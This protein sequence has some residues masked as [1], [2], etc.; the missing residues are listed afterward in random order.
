MTKVSLDTLRRTLMAGVMMISVLSINFA[1]IPVHAD[2]GD[3]HTITASADSNGSISPSGAVAVTEPND[4]S[5]TI[6]A[7]PGY[8]VADVQVDGSS[9]GAVPSYNFSAVTA[10]HTIAATFAADASASVTTNDA[11]GVTSSDATL[12]AQNGAVAGDGHSFW[13]STSHFDTSSPNI[14]AD[15]YSTNDMG[16]IGANATF[17]ATLSS[18]TSDAV[19]TG[20]AHSTMPAVTPDTTYY[21]A[22]WVNAGGNWIPGEEKTLHTSAVAATPGA[23]TNAA[24]GMTTTGATVNGTNGGVAADNT[25]FWWGT[26]SA[27]PFAASADPSTEFPAG[28]NHDSG[29]G[30]AAVSA[31]FSELLSALTPS[32]TYY[33]AAW[34]LV[35]GTWYPGAVE[36]FDTTAEDSGPT[37]TTV[38]VNDNHLHNWYL[39]DDQTD[40]VLSD[41]TDHGFVSGPA[42]AP[43][44]T[45][46]VHLTKTTNDKYGIATAQF[47]G[48]A[49]SSITQLSYSTYRASGT[50]A[51]APS[52]GF[53]VDSDTTDGDTGYQGRLTYEPYFTQTVNTGAWQDWDTLADSGT[54]N[55][56]FSHATL[57]GGAASACTQA[58][59]CTWTE[60]LAAYPHA[61]MRSVGQLIIRTNGADS[62][63]ADM[64]ADKF[65]I[66]TG[67]A[68]T[69]YDF[70]PVA[71]PTCSSDDTTFDT[72]TDGNVD[73]QHGWTKTGSYDAAIV[74]NTYDISSFGCKSLRISDAVTSGSFGDQTFS[75]STPNEAGETA[76]VNNGYSGG[77][78]TNH[79]DAQFDLASTQST[80]QSGMSLSVS[81][82]R[83]DGARMS[84]LRFDD[85]STGINVFF[86]DV[87]Q[88][89]ACAPAGCAN[90]VETQIA[91]L[92][93]SVP[94]TIKFSI[95][96]VDG[97]GNDVVKVYIDGTLVHTGTSWED[98]YRYDPE[99][100]G[101]GNQVPTVDSLLFREGGTA[102]PANSGKGYLI[103]NVGIT[104]GATPTVTVTIDKYLDG[105]MATAE[106][107][108]NA[109]FP[110][111]SS[112]TAANLGSGSGTYNLDTVHPYSPNAYE[113]I[114]SPMDV[115][116][117]YATNEVMDD[118]T[119]SST[120]SVGGAP[121][122]LQGY[123]VGDTPEDAASATVTPDAPSFTNLQAN[124]YVVVH[125]VTC[126]TDTEAPSVP[127]L[128]SPA[129][130]G[131]EN[132]NDFYFN[133]ENSTD[134]SSG[135][136]SYDS[137]FTMDSTEVGGVLQNGIWASTTPTNTIHS[138]GAPD[139]T[140]YWQVRATDP[141]SNHSDWSPIWNVTIDTHAPAAPTITSPA[142]STH[143]TSASF[144]DVTWTDESD[145]GS[146]V[147]YIYE[148]ATDS[149]TNPDG[150][151]AHPAYVSGLLS[152]TQI[153]TP[154][155]PEGTY[156][157]HVK[158][159]DAAGNESGWSEPITVT[160]DNTAP[161]ASFVFPTPGP[162]A[163]SFQVVY[164]EDVSASDA[165]NAD[166][167][168]LNNWPGAG[169]SG[170]LT[171]NASVSYDS[172]SHTA[173]VT[174]TNPAW[175]VSAEQQWGVGDVHDLADNDMTPDPTTAYSSA[176]VAP[177]A[178]GTP[179]TASPTTE[180][181]Q[182]WS[183]DA[184]VD[185]GGADASGVASYQYSVDEG[186]W[187][188]NGSATTLTTNLDVG[189]H[190]LVVRAVDNAGNV[191]AASDAGT[192]EVDEADTTAP[193]ITI[194]GDN[195]LA[196]HDGDEF[197]V[198]GA[199][200]D[201]GSEVTVTSNDV[202][203]SHS[204]TYH[205]DYEA[206]DDAGN[207]GTATLTVNVSDADAPVITVP[208]DITVDSA[209]NSGTEVDYTVTA[210]D[211]E[212]GEVTPICSPAS[213]SVFPIGTTEVD[214]SATD[215]S[216]NTGTA[217]FNVTV[218]F[219]GST[220][221]GGGKL[222]TSGSSVPNFSATGGSVLGASAFNFTV[223]FGE[224]ST[225]DPDVTE[226]Q[227]ILIAD[228]YLN[229]P[230][231]T[232]FYGPLT[233]AAVKLYQA[234]HG[235]ST[236]GYVGPLTRG[237][238]NQGT[239]QSDT[240]TSIQEQI[241][242]LMQQVKDLQDQLAST[243][244]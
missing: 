72:F 137:Q 49:L 240:G 156:Y 165:E 150:S 168:F 118:V 52:L 232:G 191:G 136:L 243:T 132:T 6:T 163:T 213:G 64:N 152:D 91:T 51:Q 167:Y 34:S 133:W 122:M 33:F 143:G 221:G 90:F 244:H 92:D 89:G 99:Q 41:T 35:G 210:T 50:S 219:T 147:G 162:S 23:T 57:S 15:V 54:G 178:P 17:T 160:V 208:D 140:W 62:E 46:S 29:L 10:D 138:Q 117:D 58:N 96:F 120:C 202:D 151:F 68:V 112:W 184:A 110:M 61:A 126:A 170:P 53:D 135:P 69:T 128:T 121:Y 5:F 11:T 14:P 16:A 205:V 189:N 229:I 187:T 183:W 65:T 186:P 114:T 84:Y 217:S 161:T 124:E 105:A 173:T 141:S 176:M 227:K 66:G 195:P 242:D 207:T 98:Y 109:A 197:T 32:T 182:D 164:S 113:A 148:S 149:S 179:T 215:S 115:G 214:C 74:D 175:Y 24:T 76:A 47:A 38:V 7:N 1:A 73:G 185:P 4:Q 192:V 188:D 155:T 111:A 93:R 22:A 231:P 238:L 239:G 116:A 154:G 146:P 103:D 19:I 88:P 159:V 220:G 203:T 130:G 70:E 60:L 36:H 198:P 55:W 127:V 25:S 199:T 71:V 234:A 56:W 235:I 212:D 18:L 79:F 21:Y 125:N 83:G 233:Q 123:S 43:A 200:A 37:P 218:N 174:F 145:S 223:D 190:T 80:Q 45:G 104:T 216:D 44:G 196:L 131:Y 134:D 94:H 108:N 172:P 42:T 102:V 224:G 180:T 142:N 75:Y 144:T 81:P 82:D 39:Y 2:A 228:G 236:T 206:T 8:H 241:N 230:A 28:W 95:D 153:P 31:P 222:G 157:V 3:I 26:T 12:N 13:V 211:N 181:T 85:S 40:H 237:A 129:N 100:A 201:D 177:G 119:V 97:A 139:G 226:L 158:S 63:A 9:V 78:R 48:T 171:G 166:N 169:G 27:G 225:L 77:T 101:S 204:G 107:A 209:D 87:Q 20:G 30:G 67:S 194:D 106:S 86:D 193:V 59:P